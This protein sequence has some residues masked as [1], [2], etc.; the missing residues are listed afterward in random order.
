MVHKPCWSIVMTRVIENA[1]TIILLSS[2]N[3]DVVDEHQE[4]NVS[5]TF[6]RKA[7]KSDKNEF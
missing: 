2:I 5:I 4:Q 1:R 3:H 7:S 6:R